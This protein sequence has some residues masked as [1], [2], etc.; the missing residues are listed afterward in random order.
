MAVV[1]VKTVMKKCV[2]I[3][4]F[5]EPKK[6]QLEHTN[7]QDIV[8]PQFTMQAYMESNLFFAEEIST[9]FNLRSNTFSGYK[10][11]YPKA[12]PKNKFCKLGC[13]EE[14]SLWHL[15]SCNVISN[16]DTHTMYN[17]V[18]YFIV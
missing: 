10:M 15:Y 1:T 9:I 4:E 16:P 18:T 5:N 8:Y 11:C 7:I 13:L 3:A 12:Y 6:I 17:M 2:K 14:N